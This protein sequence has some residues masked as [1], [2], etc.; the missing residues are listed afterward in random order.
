MKRQRRNGINRDIYWHDQYLSI[1]YEI[2]EK[3]R[4]KYKL[5]AT[6]LNTIEIQLRYD[7]NT[8]SIQF[9]YYSNVIKLRLYLISGH[10][11]TMQLRSDNDRKRL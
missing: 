6:N 2:K 7:F 4:D 3:A 1:L 11:T 10:W 5:K 8:T 9:K